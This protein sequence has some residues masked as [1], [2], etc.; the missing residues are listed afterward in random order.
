M[1]D[2]KAA[3]AARKAA[4]ATPETDTLEV[5]V[6]ELL[7]TL[8]FRELPSTVWTAIT[9]KHPPRLDVLIDMN[10]G[11]D[12]HASADEAARVSVVRVDGGEDVPFEFVEAAVDAP[13]VDDWGD[14][15][16]VLSSSDLTQ[17]RNLVWELNE[18]RPA[19]R[20]EK[21]KKA[22]AAKQRPKRP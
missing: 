7:V 17:V 21:A 4:L 13:G 2:F 9:A 19:L 18:Y 16:S 10:Y 6:G 3:L 20:T 11:Y 14:L 15:A 1:S 12:W 8:K 5:T 22:L